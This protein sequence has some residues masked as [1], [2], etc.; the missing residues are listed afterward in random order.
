MTFNDSAIFLLVMLVGGLLLIGVF[1]AGAVALS[2][3]TDSE[4]TPKPKSP[5][6]GRKARSK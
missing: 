5:W 2:M 3:F 4:A 1:V 6:S